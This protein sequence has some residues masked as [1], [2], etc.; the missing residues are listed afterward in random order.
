MPLRIDA[1]QHY[2]R[3]QPAEY[4]WISDAMPQLR[5]DFLPPQLGAL[6]AERGLDGAVL[7]QARQHW[8]ETQ[9]LLQLSRDHREILAVVGWVDLAGEALAASLEEVS[10]Q[11]KLR[12][13]RHQIQD[14]ADGAGWMQQPAVTRG[15]QQIQRAGYV[16]DLLVTHDQLAAATAFAA[17]HDRGA[18]VLDH[19]GKPDIA[20]GV[21]QWVRQVTPLAALPHVSCKLSGLLTEP[22]PAGCGDAEL[23]AFYDAALQLF[24]PER[25]LF[26]SDWPVCLL[27]GPYQH[28]WQLCQQAIATLSA[29]EQA[30]ILGGNASRIYLEPDGTGL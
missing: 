2:W 16:Y 18:L 22:R 13:F 21:A 23:L 28:G 1:H 25:L 11:A 24:G 4:G 5:Q 6:L 26:G 7:V 8:Q 20:A 19:F 3:Y 10:G 29:D 9:W 14:E 12:G 15:M 17:R 27:D 30:A